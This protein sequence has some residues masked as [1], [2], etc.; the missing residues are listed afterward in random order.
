MA[1]EKI[2]SSQVAKLAGVSQ[3]AVSRVFTPG[4]SVSPKTADKVR[5]AADQLGYRPNVLARS[6]ITGKSRIIGLVVAYLNNQFYPEVLEKLSNGLQAEGYH[7]LVFMAA[8]TSNNMDAVLGELLDYQV[9]GIVL[10][11][12]AMSSELALRCH[13]AGVPVVLFNRTQDNDSL[14]SVTSD[15]FAGGRK[16]AVHLAQSGYQRIAYIAGW[17]G[18]ST[19]RDREAGFREGLASVGMKLFAREEGDFNFEQAKVA[20]RRMFSVEE[21]PDAVFICNDHMAFAVM[22]V[23]RDELGLRIPED[24]GVVGYDDVPAA[25]WGAYK[26]TTVRQPANRMVQETVN[27]L[28]TQITQEDAPPRRLSLDAPLVVRSSSIKP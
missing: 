15:N 20:A 18:A 16:A 6:L 5:R 14:S 12:V 7:V 13:A 8:Q 25:A 3:S 26:L 27:M 2:T 17:N 23:I 28:M 21:R 9:D 4:A 10:A 19:Q 22:D 24:V 11:S 1:I